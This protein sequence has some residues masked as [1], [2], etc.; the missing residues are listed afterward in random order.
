MN[1]VGT[2]LKEV[3]KSA[4][5]K[6]FYRITQL[7]YEEHIDQEDASAYKRSLISPLQQT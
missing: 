4:L 5:T 3:G 2:K 6:Y 1:D 7:S